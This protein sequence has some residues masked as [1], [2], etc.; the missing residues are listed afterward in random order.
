MAFYRILGSWLK[1]QPFTI[2]HS[3]FL[4]CPEFANSGQQPFL[5][6]QNNILRIAREREFWL[7][8]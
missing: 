7:K 8:D 4:C 3:L 6:F 5:Y 2:H 1:A